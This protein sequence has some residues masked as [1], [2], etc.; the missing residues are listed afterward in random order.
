MTRHDDFILRSKT[1]RKNRT[2]GRMTTF[3]SALAFTVALLPAVRAFAQDPPQADAKVMNGYA[4]HQSIELGGHIADHSGSGAMWDTLVNL[5][6]GPR[7]LSNALTLHSIDQKKTPFFDDFS[8]NSFG[9]GGDP[10]DAT[11]LRM[12]KGRA[13]QLDGSF[14]RDR[15]YFDYNL[16]ANPL[17]PP[18]AFPYVPLTSSPHRF[19]TVRRMTDVGLTVL[20][21]SV[22][23]VR[24]GYSKNTMEGPT[25]ST[26]HTGTDAL[27]NQWWRNDTDSYTAG[28]DFKPTHKTTL[29][30]D[31]FVTA[32]KG[33]T[34]WK[35]TGLNYQLANGTPVSLGVDIFTGHA[36]NS[37]CVVLA[38]AANAVPTIRPNCS[39]TLTYQRYAPTRTLFPTEQ[40][41]FASADL[42]RV[43]MNG[44]ILYSG[45]TGNIDQ[46]GESFSGW[47]SRT[48]QSQILDAGSGPGG[49]FASLKR[50]SVAGDYGITVEVTPQV[51]ISDV[52]DFNS[53][54]NSGHNQYLESSLYAPNLSS[55]Q[56]TTPFYSATSGADSTSNFNFNQLKQTI[57]SNT[58]QAAWD[59]SQ[60]FKFSLGYRYRDRNITVN[61]G[62]NVLISNYNA[63]PVLKSAAG[64]PNKTT[65]C[66]VEVDTPE[67]SSV[68]PIHEHWALVGLFFQP[69]SNL[70]VNA[71]VD[72]MYADNS[73][74]EISPRQIQ[75]YR[76][77]S[78]YKA[79][80]W[81]NLSGTINIFE[82]RDNVSFVHYLHHARD[83]SFGA[84]LA[85]SE[86]W[87][88]DLN[89]AYN[90]VYRSID[91]CYTVLPVAAL[92]ITVPAGLPPCN[93]PDKV[94]NNAL[95]YLSTGY[96]NE[97][98]QFGSISIMLA[99]VK[100]V[101]ANVGYRM[102]AVDGH[103]QALNSRF[104]PG[105]LQS[106]YE[107]PYGDL[108]F[109][110]APGW[111]WKAD[112]NYYSYGEGNPI[113]PTV[114]RSFR[115]NVY[116]LGVKY[117]F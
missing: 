62:G 6:S 74:T 41:R 90:D 113:G 79:R 81:M 8:T 68:T 116:T 101:H 10:Y 92:G 47:L 61:S 1:G 28:V 26:V 32:Y 71:N 55:T 17:I 44:R 80:P 102:S 115:G 56:P 91:E 20:P 88:V 38:T 33:D 95:L 76:V 13:Y 106:Q 104:A 29:S 72:A 34:T 114:N 15:Q 7:I 27:L 103:E 60:R 49:K 3:A 12:S 100:R 22:F 31:Q 39:G 58:I 36:A 64:C 112:W 51:S 2:Y 18:T 111:T 43:T 105:S 98:T 77:R 59:P 5:Q 86:K 94:A 35:L 40:F 14:R 85:K 50:V 99:P 19:N 16:L 24:A 23:S 67:D 108:A 110:I 73:F 52:F 82:S 109:Q 97:P 4:V 96:Y 117:A 89:Y 46:Y 21:L 70:R 54:R 107:T 84:N 66:S 42:K 9:Y 11:I 78:T 93:D 65:A 25:F 87:S 48:G 53:F 69:T 57:K 75:H 83:Y 63:R 37:T 45:A 30:Y